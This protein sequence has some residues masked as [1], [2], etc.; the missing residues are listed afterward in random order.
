MSDDLGAKATPGAARD[1]RILG[2]DACTGST[3]VVEAAAGW[4]G[5]TT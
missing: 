5:P 3:A 4:T 2:T 1:L